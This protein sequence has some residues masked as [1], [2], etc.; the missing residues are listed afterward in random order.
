M[1][2]LTS[3]LVFDLGGTQLRAGWFA[4]GALARVSRMSSDVVRGGGDP[5][6]L[7]EAAML[8]LAAQVTDGEPGAVSL[9]VPGPVHDGVAGRLPS[10]LGPGYQGGLDFEALARRLWPGR[11]VFASNDLT[12]DDY[13]PV[14]ESIAR[15]IRFLDA[16]P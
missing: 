2:I 5:A 15:S 9:A 7:L 4:D 8:D 11:P 3:V 12:G 10:L 13:A 14:F 16:T 1:R 6:A